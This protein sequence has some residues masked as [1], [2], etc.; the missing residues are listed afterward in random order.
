MHK[1]P[2]S[3]P[4][5]A[6][7]ADGTLLTLIAAR[8][9]Q[10]LGALYD[11]YGRLVFSV[12]LRVVGDPGQAEEIT[13]DTFLR[14]WN[15]SERYQ[16]AL[17]SP[18]TWLLT[19][20][21]RRAI[22]ELRSRRGTIARSEVPLASESPLPAASEQ[23]HLRVDVAE[24]LGNLPQPQREA[25]ELMF[26]AGLSRQEIASRTGAPLGTIHTRLRLGLEK[27]R[28]LLLQTGHSPD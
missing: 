16:P 25:V 21:R 9:H 15:H 23:A 13:Q 7:S 27:L 19:I 6:D 3:P 5:A 20:A 8:D 18:Q 14:V 4:A 12:A 11:R 26:W 17:G 10:A 22:D 1:G 2:I 24:A 28:A